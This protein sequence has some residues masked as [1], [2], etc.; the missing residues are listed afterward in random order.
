MRNGRKIAVSRS[1]TKVGVVFRDVRDV[2]TSRARLRT[3]G[4]GTL[5]DY[6]GRPNSRVKV[7]KL[8]D[9]TSARSALSAQDPAVES[10]HAMYRFAAAKDWS[11]GTGTVIARVQTHLTDKERDALWTEHGATVVKPQEG[12]PNTYVLRP[13]RDEDEV[14]VA[15]RLAGDP[16]TVWAQANFRNPMR[17][18][19]IIPDDEFF[20]EQWHLDNN[21]QRGGT[22]GADIRAPE[23]WEI[24]NGQEVLIGMFDDACDFNHPDLAPGYLGIGHDPSF[25]SNSDSFE[26]PSPK[27]PADNHGTR[28]MGLAVARANAIGVRGVAFQ[29]RFTASRGLST[30]ISDAQLAT[31]YTFALQR[32]VDVHINSWGFAP[33]VPNPAVVEDAIERAFTE[34]RADFDLDGDDED[35]P[36]GMVIVFASGNSDL[37]N[38]PGLEISTLP[39]VLSVG[40]SHDADARASLSNFGESLNFLAPS[41]DTF[42]AGLATVDN[43]DS[44]AIAD[45]GA[46]IGG[47]NAEEEGAPD[48]LDEAGEYTA[49]FSGTS[50]ACPIAAGIAALVLSANPLLTA[51]DARIIMEH[52]AVPINPTSADYHPI[53]SRSLRYGYGRVDALAAAQAAERSTTTGNTT[54]PDVPA[55]LFIG[56][57]RQL[58]WRQNVGTDEFLVLES[59]AEF[60]FVPEDL[61]CYDNRQ[62]GCGSAE[63]DPLPEGVSV[64]AVGCDLA[65][66]GGAP[67]D[68]AV[69][70]EKCVDYLITSGAKHFAVFARNSQGRYS[71]GVAADSLGNVTDP[72]IITSDPFGGLEGT[73]GGDDGGDGGTTD[74]AVTIRA[75]PLEGDSPLSV[76]FQGNAVSSVAIDESRTTWDFDTEDAT[77]VDSTSRTDV[78]TYTVSAGQTRTFVAQL[79]MFDIQGRVGSASVSIR[80]RGAET[81]DP[82]D[83]AAQRLP[84]ITIGTPD[85][86]SARISE[87]T[88]PLT[89][90]LSLDTDTVSGTLESVR[91]DLGDG[92][93]INSLTALHTYENVSG[94]DQRLVITG[95]VNTRSATGTP[96]TTN[97]TTFLLLHPSD[98]D[99][100]TGTPDLPGTGTGG[101]TDATDM[102]GVTGMIPLLLV[103]MSLVSLR[104]I[105]RAGG[106]D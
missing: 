17:S 71:F 106:R 38:E 69:T 29:S 26:D 84:R 55:D 64:L 65:C 70:E 4:G 97:A 102:C 75:T 10:V 66:G 73:G 42:R 98:P 34:G 96:A 6:N 41:R 68:C 44:S 99:S 52:T 49:F 86:P 61:R 46:N 56:D 28:V 57:G 103:M 72:G 58:R 12:L 74:V 24:A 15:E 48:D 88:S 23:A 11:I 78:H 93:I 22:P 62:T 43:R 35:D 79:T 30:N 104:W 27:Q 5:E 33:G 105:R 40:A 3:L 92:T 67:T 8:S 89:V 21:G 87:G 91:W 45:P 100:D 54:W 16:R 18:R 19:Q 80:V 53:T 47:I 32:E 1:D 63:I 37:L 82:T 50:G 81:E 14:V 51:D 95:V 25:P 36:L 77:T 2:P 90:Q 60:A 31:V 94:R 59:D 39:W 85:N 76:Q 20:S 101:G 7:L 9:A 13:A 83:A